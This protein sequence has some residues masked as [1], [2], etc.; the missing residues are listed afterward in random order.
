MTKF[1]EM[2]TKL[3]DLIKQDVEWDSTDWFLYWLVENYADFAKGDKLRG[4][5]SSL[6]KKGILEKRV[7]RF[8]YGLDTQFRFIK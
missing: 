2:E 1:T 8:D 4:V 6:V 3:L 5:F 7:V